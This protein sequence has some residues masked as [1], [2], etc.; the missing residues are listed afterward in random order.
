MT[1]LDK[2]REIVKKI[3]PSEEWSTKVDKMNDF[4]ITIIYKRLKAELKV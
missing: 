3:N 2:Q 4:Q 1:T